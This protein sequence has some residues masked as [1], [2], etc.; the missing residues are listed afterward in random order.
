MI[1]AS[2]SGCRPAGEP[3]LRF[4]ATIAPLG[5]ILAELCEDRAP[6]IVLM[7]PGASPHTFDPSP[8]VARKATGCRAVF[9]V[10]ASLD[11][12]VGGMGTG[13]TV[14][15]LDSCLPAESRLDSDEVCEHSAHDHTGHKSAGID[16]R[17]PHFWTDPLAVIACLPGLTAELSRLDP[18][19]RSTYEANARRFAAEIRRQLPQMESLLAGAR[20]KTV[21]T[22]HPSFNYLFRRYGIRSAGSL[23]QW[24]GEEAAPRELAALRDRVK[25]AGAAVLFSEQG[26]P[27]AAAQSFAGQCGLRVVMLYPESLP[28][29][30][31]D[32]CGWLGANAALLADALGGTAAL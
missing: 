9:Q 2:A 14:S 30:C 10:A 3:P 22:M 26:L 15:V 20:G 18:E 23:E 16:C 31:E 21:L 25:A 1:L 5:L 4:G 7:P 8:S 6:V 17:D 19:G 27:T 24:A 11:G 32:Y 28:P 12:W 13:E 29:G